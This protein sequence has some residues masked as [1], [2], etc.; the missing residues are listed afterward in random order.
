MLNANVYETLFEW[1]RITIINHRPVVFLTL[2]PSFS[3]ECRAEVPEPRPITEESLIVNIIQLPE[4]PIEKTPEQI[5]DER[6]TRRMKKNSIINKVKTA[7]FLSLFILWNSLL[8]QERDILSTS[9]MN[10]YLQN[11]FY[12]LRDAEYEN[13]VE[14][15]KYIIGEVTSTFRK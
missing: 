5:L 14:I 3:Y 2:T 13:T 10:S 11:S 7:L 1:G 9:W 12:S 4:H 6:F 8:Y 15:S